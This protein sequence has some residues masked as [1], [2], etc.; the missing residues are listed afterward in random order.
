MKRSTLT[1]LWIAS[2]VLFAAV[3]FAW[4]RSE[5]IIDEISWVSHRGSVGMVTGGA[6][7]IFR[8][9]RFPGGA[10]NA[11]AA[12]SRIEHFTALPDDA[13]SW[14]TMRLSR[15]DRSHS[16]FVPF[17]MPLCALASILYVTHY[18]AATPARQR[19]RCGKK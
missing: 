5:R 12:P 18:A 3:S 4:V 7:V 17:W 9:M 6:G 16:L 2:A 15:S 19:G 11:V 10:V 13:P 14:W 8:M 1:M